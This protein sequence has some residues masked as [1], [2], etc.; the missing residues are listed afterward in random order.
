ME[1]PYHSYQ[2]VHS[3]EQNHDKSRL[4]SFKYLLL[5]S[6]NFDEL[7]AQHSS[8]SASPGSTPHLIED[9]SNRS[10]SEDTTR[11][12]PR[13]HSPYQHYKLTSLFTVNKSARHALGTAK[14]IPH[15]GGRPYRVV[16]DSRRHNSLLLPRALTPKSRTLRSILK[17]VH[18]GQGDSD[19]TAGASHSTSTE[20]TVHSKRRTSERAH[21]AWQHSIGN[22]YV[23]RDDCHLHQILIHTSPLPDRAW[24][25]VAPCDSSTISPSASNMKE[26]F[27]GITSSPT[28]A[29][30]KDTC[31]VTLLQTRQQQ[32]RKNLFRPSQYIHLPPNEQQHDGML[33]SEV[34]A[35]FS[36]DKDP[37][38]ISP[39][40]TRYYLDIFFNYQKHTPF[41]MFA[42]LPRDD[43]IRW[44]VRCQTYRSLPDRLMIYALM[45]YATSL[46]HSRVAGTRSLDHQ[47]EFKVIVYQEIEMSTLR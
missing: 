27:Y 13:L 5:T 4:P 26:H 23:H 47:A 8:L 11:D 32:P 10:S 46:E 16:K 17:H 6:G 43:F 30:V 19:H 42:M 2:S 7:D 29:I 1:V 44:A 45:L 15:T 38:V 18:Q 9:C 14:D 21:V 40:L 31:A 25:H 28:K 12:L 41:P 36:R 3:H 34:D 33:T 22:E 20:A 24:S 39:K 35:P 37:A